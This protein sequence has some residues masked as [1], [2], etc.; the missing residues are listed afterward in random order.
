MEFEVLFNK[1]SV[2]L[3]YM[4]Q[5]SWYKFVESHPGKQYFFV[6]KMI[7][8]HMPADDVDTGKGTPE[9]VSHQ[10]LRADH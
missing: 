2:V 3:Q 8:H 5:A 7:S 1:C 9:L 10:L 4:V 6:Q